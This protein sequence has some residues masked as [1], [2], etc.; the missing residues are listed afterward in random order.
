MAVDKDKLTILVIYLYCINTSV[1]LEY[2]SSK[3]CPNACMIWK[4]QIGVIH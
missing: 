1:L 3:K 2:S 4:D